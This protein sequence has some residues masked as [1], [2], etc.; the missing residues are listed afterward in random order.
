MIRLDLLFENTTK[1]S[2]TIYSKFVAFHR[3][4]YQFSYILYTITVVV[5]ILC[6]LIFQF[7]THNF[8]LAL[9]LCCALIFFMVWRLTHPSQ[10][11]SKEYKSNKIQQSKEY[12][13]KF[14]SN[15]F[16]VEDKK[17]IFELKY[18]KLYHI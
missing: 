7:Q 11:I 18:Y 6:G 4:K 8:C 3:K 5:F 16:T 13:F 10:V 15:Y 2:K 9:V 14:Y 1:Y 17:E 12:T